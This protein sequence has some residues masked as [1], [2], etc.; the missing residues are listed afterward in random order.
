[1]VPPGIVPLG[2]FVI[3]QAGRDIGQTSIVDHGKPPFILAAKGQ[4][5]TAAK[6]KKKMSGMSN[7]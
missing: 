1:M 7:L 4:I 6:P 2:Q 3:S 5:R